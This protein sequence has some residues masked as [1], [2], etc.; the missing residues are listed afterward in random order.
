MPNQRATGQK[1]VIVVMKE[2]FLHRIDANLE[3]MGFSD[4]SQFI[5][6]A[7]AEALARTGSAVPKEL[8]VAPSRAG[9]G[10]R[11]KKEIPRLVL[12]AES[13]N[14]PYGSRS[15]VKGTKGKKG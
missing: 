5:R 8:T 9:K 13:R 3:S 11:P 10:G 6:T 1:Q 2:D 12:V 4:R 7:V 15:N 14:E